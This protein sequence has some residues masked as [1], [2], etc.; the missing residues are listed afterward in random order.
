MSKYLSSTIGRKQIVGITGLLLCIFLLL[1]V[2]GNLIMFFSAKAYNL[3]GH[4][5]TSNPFIYVA[6]LG[7]CVLFLGHMTQAIYLSVKNKLA[8]PTAYVV[9]AKGEK[10]TPIVTQFM[11]QQG[12][13]ILVF[14]VLHLITF[15]Y[16]TIYMV[17]YNGVEVRD[18]FRL[19]VE[20]FQSPVYVA[21]YV[22]ALIVLGLHLSH[23]FQST[24]K[25]LGFNHPK[26]E[27][28]IKLAGNLFTAFVA[29]GFIIQP[30][31]VFFIY[32][33]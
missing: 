2:S 24:F 25:T 1:H 31:Y 28:K 7:L 13:I 32:K 17:D 5:M 9:V 23:G 8:R 6:E 12:V 21:W 26:Y 19:I 11:W 15:K 29:I 27:P 33:G 18:L 3:Y 22:V 30:L 4:A 14:V 10:K 16:G 20:V